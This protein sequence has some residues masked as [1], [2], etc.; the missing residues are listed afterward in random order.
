M[1]IGLVALGAA[2]ALAAVLGPLVLG[3]LVYRTS[4]TSLNQIVGADAASLFL[5]APFSVVVGVL[6]LLGRPRVAGLGLAP[7]VYAAYMETQL[8]LGNEFLDR[9]GNVER[10]FPMLVGIFVLAV[11][12]AGASW[13]AAGD[14]QDV[15]APG[16]D[17]LAGVVLLAAAAFVTLGLHVPTYLDAVSGSPTYTGYLSSPTAFWLVKFMDLGIV[18]PAAVAIGLGTLAGRDWAR[19][20]LRAVLGAYGLLATSVAAMAVVM[21][22]RDDPDASLAAVVVASLVAVALLSLTVSLHRSTS[23]RPAVAAQPRELTGSPS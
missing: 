3:L 11:T 4:P 18:V 2:I 10:F 12:V 1:G 17:R 6:V 8:A 9:P 23:R 21:Y 16:R 19:R 14:E 13:R 15:A 5:V 20:P 22:A 7:A